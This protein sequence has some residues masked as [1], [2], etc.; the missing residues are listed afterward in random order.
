MIF[1]LLK[2]WYHHSVFTH[3][4]KLVSVLH[5][6]LLFY[7]QNSGNKPDACKKRYCRIRIFTVLFF[8][9]EHYTSCRVQ[10]VE[11][12]YYCCCSYYAAAHYTWK[13]GFVVVDFDW[14]HL[15]AKLSTRISVKCKDLGDICCTSQGLIHFVLNLVAVAVATMVVRGK[16]RLAAFDVP[17]NK[18]LKT[19]KFRLNLLR[20]SRYS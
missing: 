17:S 16:I 4:H 20:N 14:R 5:I 15:I 3:R 6:Y 12:V 10:N 11:R 19:Q 2:D 8:K 7:C 9:A 18:T 1:V 13:S